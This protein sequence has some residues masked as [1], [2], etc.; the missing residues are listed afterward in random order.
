MRLHLVN[1]G[2]N[3]GKVFK[4]CGNWWK[5]LADGRRMCWEGGLFHGTLPR[6]LEQSQKRMTADISWQVRH[7]PQ[8]KRG[9]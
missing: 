7:G 4:R 5:H 1:S 2:P 9:R 8:V 6:S 3:S